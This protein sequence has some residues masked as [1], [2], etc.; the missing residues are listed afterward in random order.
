MEIV[1]GC[2]PLEGETVRRLTSPPGPAGIRWRGFGLPPPPFCPARP[3]ALIGVR[4]VPE[5][6]SDHH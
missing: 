3:R 4:A 5:S 6:D 1:R 2:R